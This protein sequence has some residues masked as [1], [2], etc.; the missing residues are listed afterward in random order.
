MHPLRVMLSCKSMNKIILLV[1]R[2]LILYFMS[3]C[4]RMFRILCYVLRQRTLYY[5]YTVDRSPPPLFS[6]VF[7]R[8][9]DME[10]MGCGLK[11]R[12]LA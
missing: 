10:Y 4:E 1:K 3:K 6:R 2:P 12:V 11:D 5:I 7:I 9:G 8:K